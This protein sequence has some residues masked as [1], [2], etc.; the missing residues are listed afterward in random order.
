MAN[1]R[2]KKLDELFHDT[3]KDIVL[4]GEEDSHRASQDGKGSAIA[5]AEKGLRQAQNRDR[6]AC[7]TTRKGLRSHRQEAARQDLRR[8]RRHHR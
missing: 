4:R 8:D 5:R 2:A 3:L 6:G 1:K 7:E